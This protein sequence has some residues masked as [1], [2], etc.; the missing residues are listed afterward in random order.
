MVGIARILAIF[1]CLFLSPQ[2]ATAEGLRP[3]ILDPTYRHDRFETEPR[4]IMR[5]FRAYTTSFDSDDD[6]NG[7]GEPDILGIPQWVAQEIRRAKKSPESKKRPQAWFSE[8]ELVEVGIAPKDASYAYPKKFRDAH[9]NWFDR[10]HLAQKYL[11]ERMG[12]DA[13]WNTHTVLNAV[14]QRSRFNSGPWLELECL[15][16]AWANHF[17]KV[18]IVTG[19]V[20]LDGHPHQWI[21]EKSK[22]ELSVAVPDALF[23]IVIR[24]ATNAPGIT[25]LA[26]IYPQDD[27]SY[28]KGP[29]DHS[30]W[31][32]SVDEVESL[33]GLDFLTALPAKEQ[34]KLERKKAS[35]LWLREKSDFDSGCKRFAQDGD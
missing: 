21:G 19:P 20:F 5:D 27:K 6:D 10:G 11:A 9:P 22:S 17:G 14:P 23:K 2:A 1:L 15:T 8:E 12:A 24:E 25:V 28:A 32:V 18:W 3:N 26:F 13:A 34:A 31:L 29:W 7:D 35:A 30:L 4:D 33:T 16:G